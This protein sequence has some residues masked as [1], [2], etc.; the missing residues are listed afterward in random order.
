[1]RT[2]ILTLPA[3]IAVLTI[4]TSVFALWGATDNGYAG[5]TDNFP[6]VA[7]IEGRWR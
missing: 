3:A 7:G 1:M 5:F 4:C 2:T 6:G